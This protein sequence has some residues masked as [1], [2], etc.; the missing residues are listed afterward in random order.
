[1]GTGVP[2]GKHSTQ[3]HPCSSPGI[4]SLLLCPAVSGGAGE[5]RVGG[6]D[7]SW[8]HHLQS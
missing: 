4:C 2:Q 8:P 5:T 6:Q 1:M 7:P 3:E